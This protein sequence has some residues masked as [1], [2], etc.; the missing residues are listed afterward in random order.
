MQQVHRG[1]KGAQKELTLSYHWHTEGQ[2]HL[3]TLLQPKQVLRGQTVLYIYVMDIVGSC[4][5]L[6]VSAW[7][8]RVIHRDATQLKS[9][10][11]DPEE[12]IADP[13]RKTTSIF[14]YLGIKEV[15]YLKK[16]DPAAMR[17]LTAGVSEQT[18]CENCHFGPYWRTQGWTDKVITDNCFSTII[19][20]KTT[21][22]QIIK[23][24]KK[25]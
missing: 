9:I 2:S 1:S 20:S 25:L 7:G 11:R 14:P 6:R 16:K 18:V 12:G 15:N 17:P 22:R 19:K 10:Y 3:Q 4:D 5:V 13:E 21:D 24:G 23:R 8:E